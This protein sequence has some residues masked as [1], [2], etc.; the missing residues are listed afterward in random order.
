MKV[1]LTFALGREVPQTIYTSTFKIMP[2]ANEI[3]PEAEET[4]DLYV[5]INNGQLTVF[6]EFGGDS[7]LGNEHKINQRLE[8]FL[9]NYE[10]AELFY[11]L[12]N[13]NPGLF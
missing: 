11:N 2:V 6:P 10:F 4:S 9:R 7:L 3:F 5:H 13:G 12:T 8:R 1:I